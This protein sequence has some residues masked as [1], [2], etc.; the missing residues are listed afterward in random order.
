MH[1]TCIS[2]WRF[3]IDYRCVNELT[4]KN[5]FPMPVIDEMMDELS[6]AR[7]FSKLDLRAGY[8]HICVRPEDE[9]KTVFKTLQG[10]Y[11]FPVMPFGLCNALAT[12]QCVM[13]KVL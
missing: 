10:H 4:I 7:V 8:H 11:Q 1:F 6:G 13:S 2:S 3:C 5:V 12:F 9:H